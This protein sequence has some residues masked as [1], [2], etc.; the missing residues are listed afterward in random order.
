MKKLLSLLCITCL[1]SGCA[2]TTVV[3]DVEPTDEV[4]TSVATEA[5]HTDETTTSVVTESTTPDEVTTSV[6]TEKTP[7]ETEETSESSVLVLP[8]IVP[9]TTTASPTTDIVIDSDSDNDS[10]YPDRLSELS[11]NEVTYLNTSY[12]SADGTYQAKL[13]ITDKAIVS[14]IFTELKSLEIFPKDENESLYFDAMK[15]EG[16]YFGL[17]NGDELTVIFMTSD[18]S[19]KHIG[20]NFHGEDEKGTPS[21]LLQY[22]EYQCDYTALMDKCDELLAPIAKEQYSEKNNVAPDQERSETDEPSVIGKNFDGTSGLK[23]YPANIPSVIESV[24]RCYSDKTCY[25]T[26]EYSLETNKNGQW[27]TVEPLGELEQ[28]N[29][30]EFFDM[31]LRRKN[32]F[33]NLACYP[34]LPAGEYRVTK[35]YK[36]EGD[37][38]VYTAYYRFDLKDMPEK[39]AKIDGSITCERPVYPVGCRYIKALYNYN[40]GIFSSS[41]VYDVERKENGEWVSVRK[42]KIRTNSIVSGHSFPFKDGVEID[43]SLFDLSKEGEYRIRLSVGEMN[44]ELE[45]FDRYSTLYAYFSLEIMKLEGISIECTDNELNDMDEVL[46]FVISNDSIDDV[47]V[48]NAV[49][50]D[51]KGNVILEKSIN[52]TVYNGN[53]KEIK[54]SLKTPLSAGDYTVE[55]SF[56][57]RGYADTTVTA[58][59]KVA[60][61]SDEEKNSGVFITLDKNSYPLNAGK[62]EITVE[63]K[64]YSKNDILIYS[65]G[66][67]KDNDPICIGTPVNYGDEELIVKYGEKKTF[68]LKNYGS[69]YE[70]FK[71]YHYDMF[72]DTGDIEDEELDEYFDGLLRELWAEIEGSPAIHLG[73]EGEYKIGL[74]YIENTDGDSIFGETDTI[75][76]KFYVK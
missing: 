76:A 23:S 20:L 27:V 29:S 57:A 52:S 59:I 66:G 14:E 70:A 38:T 50:K 45:F 53:D 24:F 2:Q 37:E 32:C 39:E 17:E 61:A 63:N 71:S 40:G 67:Y 6:V 58:S 13:D 3:S 55:F 42:G 35:P 54:I 25:T 30:T 62:I 51:K 8:E 34:L 19:T 64:L 5:T 49:L 72:G 69:S 73:I 36:V 1:L 28:E 33:V 4:T 9:I 21:Y 65:I 15:D 18:D 43:S 12:Y 41:D 47:E 74:M 26:F 7:I 11:G 60:E 22:D 44:D 46:N 16:L 10:E 56:E 75:E 68:T 31:Y 48:V